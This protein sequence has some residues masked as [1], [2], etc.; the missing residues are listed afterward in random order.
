M[1]ARTD[2]GG[3]YRFNAVKSQWEAITDHLIASGQM[4]ISGPGVE[5]VAIDP[6]NTDV[7]YCASG[8]IFRSDDR[9]GTWKSFAITRSDGSPVYMGPNDDWRNMGERLGVAPWGG[10]EILFFGSRKDGLFRSNDHGQHWTSVSSLNAKGKSGP[11]VGFVKFSTRPAHSIYV[12]VSGTGVFRSIDGGS[13]WALLDG[14]GSGYNPMRASVA[15]EGSC[16]VTFC[17]ANQWDAPKGGAVWRY[18]RSSS[19]DITPHGFSYGYC[20]VTADPRNPEHVVIAPW[21]YANSKSEITLETRDGGKSWNGAETRFSLPDWWVTYASQN[22]N[23]TVQFD[24]FDSNKLWLANGYGVYRTDNFNSMQ[25]DWRLKSNGL[26][27]LC[28]MHVLKIPG[29]S[30]PLLYSAMDIVGVSLLDN[31]KYPAI[32]WDVG[33]HG[34]GTGIDY[35]FSQPDYVVRCS[36]DSDRSRP[37]S[38]YSRDGG[39]TWS[40]FLSQPSDGG[41]YGSI[42]VSCDSPGNLIWATCGASGT[43][44]FTMDGGNRWEP[45]HGQTDTESAPKGNWFSNFYGVASPICADKHLPSTFYCYS[46]DRSEFWRSS[47]GGKNWKRVSSG[48]L[49]WDWRVVLRADPD[50]PKVVWAGF[51]DPDHSSLWRSQDGGVSWSR[52][53]GISRLFAYGFGK[54]APGRKHDAAFL[55]AILNDGRRGIFRSDNLTESGHADWQRIDSDQAPVPFPLANGDAIDGDPNV[56]GKVYVSIPGR[57]LVCGMPGDPT[58]H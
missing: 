53:D 54:A 22:W 10:G 1:Y 35:C 2:V 17:K 56:F 13:V 19:E 8:K 31:G 4:G 15:S 18:S 58:Q 23:A 14:P 27:E 57:G 40:P 55:A 44:W 6:T 26:E 16:S 11:G 20:G 9:G 47:N 50:A 43:I 24:Q 37:T 25:Q 51:F 28:G 42:A 45:A 36:V 34:Y 29:S 30:R 21:P 12:G 48:V 46:I 5:S 41:Q 39:W 3:L 7:V 32:K 38:S 52:I 33:I 49:P